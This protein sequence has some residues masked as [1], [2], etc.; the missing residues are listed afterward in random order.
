[1]LNNDP[2]HYSAIERF[3][4]ERRGDTE[5]GPED[6]YSLI[7]VARDSVTGAYLGTAV[8]GSAIGVPVWRLQQ[9][10]V[11]AFLFWTALLAGLFA[12][13]ALHFGR[14]GA[15]LVTLIA[16]AASLTLFTAWSGFKS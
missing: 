11:A 7:P 6:P 9:P 4:Q 2:A 8:L 3:L 5:G 10:C 15:M 13:R 14:L 12:M 1:E 16:G